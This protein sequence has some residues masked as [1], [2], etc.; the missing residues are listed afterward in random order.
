MAALSGSAP[1]STG[2]LTYISVEGEIC[3][4]N[5]LQPKDVIIAVMGE[6]GSG[7]STFISHFNKHA[8]IGREARSKTDKIT[9][10]EAIIDGEQA[11]LV[12]TIGTN[13][14]ER[15][16][17][18]ILSELIK[19]LSLAAEEEV[20]LSGIIYLYNVMKPRVTDSDTHELRKFKKLCGSSAFKSRIALATTFWSVACQTE[21]T[22]KM[23]LNTEQQF[24][25]WFWSDIEADERIPVQRVRSDGH[26]DAARIIELMTKKTVNVKV[27]MLQVQEELIDGK[28]IL[29]TEVGK[30]V[31]EVKEVAREK[32]EKKLNELKK[33]AE[34]ET[35]KHSLD[36]I[37][38]IERKL[39]AKMERDKEDIKLLTMGV[40]DLLK[41]YRGSDYRSR[42]RVSRT[43]YRVV[44]S[45]GAVFI[46]SKSILTL[47]LAN[48]ASAIR[49]ATRQLLRAVERMRK[50]LKY[51]IPWRW[52][53]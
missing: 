22:K 42:H 51:F 30:L 44:G 20:Y 26:E 10:Y 13:D 50:A 48:A 49:E 38:S 14:A 35:D 7:K 29:E 33:E 21:V 31:K 28:T 45:V 2:F 53:R 12:D 3:P 23:A 18:Y 1:A 5:R 52:R 11:F 34:E 17:G 8:E 46:N 41:A 15:D 43:R 47:C 39:L 25:Q 16:E 36:E 24:E 4:L 9:A 6:T 40:E 32:N 19:W 27:E 37:T